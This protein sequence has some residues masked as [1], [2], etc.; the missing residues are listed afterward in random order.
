MRQSLLL[1]LFEF[2]G[3]LLVFGQVRFAL[4]NSGHAIANLFFPAPEVF[5]PAYLR[6]L[7]FELKV[8]AE[9]K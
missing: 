2:V 4:P 5:A 9:L 8:V 7:Q 1:G 6:H 3:C